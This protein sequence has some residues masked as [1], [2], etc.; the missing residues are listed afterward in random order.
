M[1]TTEIIPQNRY[2]VPLSELSK[3][4]KNAKRAV[5]KFKNLQELKSSKNVS[6]MMLVPKFLDV[7]HDN[8]K[9]KDSDD[10]SLRIGYVEIVDALERGVYL[11]NFNTTYI[12]L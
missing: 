6:H 10:N 7:L 4:G 3:A 2:Y 12:E 1:T 5:A 9:L 11:H 8:L